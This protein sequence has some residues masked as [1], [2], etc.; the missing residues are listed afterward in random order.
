MMTM[1]KLFIFISVLSFGEVMSQDIHFSQFYDSPLNMSPALTGLDAPFR[2]NLNYRNQWSTF[3]KP[4][5]TIAGSVDMALLKGKN[6]KAYLGAGLNFFQDKAGETG[7]SK[8]LLGGNISS[9]LKA[10]NNSHI[11][12][13]FQGAFNQR[14]VNLTDVRWDNQFNGTA[15]DPTLPSGESSGVMKKSFFDM[16]AGLAYDYSSSTTNMTSNDDFTLT[17]A[18]GAFHLNRPDQ[19]L[20]GEDKANMRMSGMMKMHIG[21]KGTNMAFEPLASY[22]KQGGLSEINFGMLMRYRL[23]SGST[24]TGIN[25]ESAISFGACYRLQDALYPII[26]YDFSN[27]SIGISYD[28]N[29]SSLTPYSQSRGGFEIVLKVRDVQGTFFGGGGSTRFF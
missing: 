19:G 9:I 18:L 28:V 1:R 20:T 27:Y 12:L 6:E 13:G 14:S 26:A 2:A 4:F 15:Y 5:Q 23:K 8:M 17:I 22:M 16:G 29:L 11:S 7:L 21:V 24:H 25:S 10:G 3:G